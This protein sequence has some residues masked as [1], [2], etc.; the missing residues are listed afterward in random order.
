MIQTAILIAAASCI[1]IADPDQRAYCRALEVG[2]P[3]ACTAIQDY[4]LRQ[5]CRVE[6]GENPAN[7]QTITD[8]TQREL[9]KAR[10]ARG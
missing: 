8:P 4:N 6:L 10:A 3:H 7:C 9:C 5:R 1:T 2:Q